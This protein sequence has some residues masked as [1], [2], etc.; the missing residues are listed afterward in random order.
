[1]RPGPTRRR[2]TPSS[3]ARCLQ[4]NVPGVV[5]IAADDKGVLYEGAFGQRDLDDGAAMTPDT[6]FWIASMTKA[7]TADAAMQLVEQGKLSLDAPIADVL[8][9]L[10]P[11]QVLDG[12]DAA[13]APTLRPAEAADHAPPSA[14]P[15]RRLRLRHLERR[16]AALP[17]GHQACPASAPAAQARRRWSSTR[18]SA[19][20]TASTSTGSARRSS[21]SAT[22]RSR[23]TSASTSSSRSAWPTRAS[24]IGPDQRAALRRCTAAG[25]RL[26]RADR[27]SRCRSAPEFFMGGGGLFSDRPR[28][29]RLPADAAGRWPLDGARVLRPETVAMMGQNQIGD[30]RG[31]ACSAVRPTVSNDAEFFPG[32][33]KKWGLA[34]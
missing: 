17:E 9:E 10:A 24:C 20:S 7:V 31:R 26:A 32:M 6:V 33:V 25:R 27:R 5:A 11:P 15:H 3:T 29:L 34:F 28:L 4:G 12:F 8:P 16:H 21:R 13:G 1:M 30:S 14:D 19:G 2:S 18:A 22:S 23:P